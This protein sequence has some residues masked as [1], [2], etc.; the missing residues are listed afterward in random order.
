MR[1][2]KWGE[3]GILCCLSLAER[4]KES[5]NGEDKNLDGKV[6]A[7]II[8]EERGIPVQYTQQIL[9]RLKKGGIVSTVRG[10][11]GGYI[12]SR[13][14]KEISL[15]DILCASEGATFEVICDIK[16]IYAECCNEP[17]LCELQTVWRELKETVDDFLSK[18]KL[19]DLLASGNMRVLGKK[20]SLNIEEGREQH[21]AGCCADA[22]SCKPH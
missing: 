14:P 1:I 20:K 13:S 17:T 10:A 21:L 12:L 16:P 4:H 5:K 22:S 8:A 15:K 3:Y 19:S 7:S 11:K 6:T 18:R 2:S 9:H